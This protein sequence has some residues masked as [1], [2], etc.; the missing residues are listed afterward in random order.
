MNTTIGI[1]S[2][3][4]TAVEAI[5]KLKGSGYPVANLSLVGLMDEEKVDDQRHVTPVNPLKPVGLGIGTVVG[6]TL[7]ILTG[8]GIFAIPGFGFLF[9]AGAVAGAVA[10]FDFGII[11][12]GIAAV[13]S[14]LGVKDDI[15]EKY[16]DALAAGKYLV[17]AHGS[18]EEVNQAKMLLHELDTHEA[19]ESH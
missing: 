18:K 5:L 11:G 19:I 1:Y 10:G 15:A 6:T 13:V 14:T 16:H 12:G 9:G 8:I 17:V 7:G 3:H 4:D 2:N